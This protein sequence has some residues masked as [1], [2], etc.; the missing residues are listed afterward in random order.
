MAHICICIYS[1]WNEKA[2]LL[3]KTEKGDNLLFI[4]KD[5]DEYYYYKKTWNRSLSY[6]NGTVDSPDE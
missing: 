6:K 4:M 1:T 2:K 3:E 5:D